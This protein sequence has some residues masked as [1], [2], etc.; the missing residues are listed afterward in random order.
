MKELKHRFTKWF[1]KQTN[2][3]GTLWAERF[4]SVLVEDSVEAVSAVA[5]YID[6]NPVRAGMVEDPREYRFCGFAEAAAGGRAARRG[7]I[8]FMRAQTGGWSARPM[9]RRC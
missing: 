2:R 1:N 5:M 6:L 3:F 7:L 9:R 8:G 4:K